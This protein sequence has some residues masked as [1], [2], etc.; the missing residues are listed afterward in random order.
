MAPD[1]TF[2]L[3]A[4]MS[5]IGV[6]RIDSGVEEGSEISLYYDPMVSKLTTWAATREQAIARMIRDKGQTRAHSPTA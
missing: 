3:V 1:G 5:D 2:A 6:L 4:G